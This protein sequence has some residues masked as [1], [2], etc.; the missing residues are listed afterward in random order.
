MSAVIIVD[1]S[2][3]GS[4]TPTS[5]VRNQDYLY[6]RIRECIINILLLVSLH[7]VLNNY[8]SQITPNICIIC[9]AQFSVCI[10]QYVLNRKTLFKRYVPM[11]EIYKVPVL[12]RLANFI[13]KLVA[14]F[15]SAYILASKHS[16]YFE[17]YRVSQVMMY[18]NMIIMFIT[19]FF[20]T[21]FIIFLM[22]YVIRNHR[23]RTREENFLRSFISTHTTEVESIGLITDSVCVVCFEK[24][25][26]TRLQ[27]CGH[28][29]FCKNCISIWAVNCPVCRERITCVEV[30]KQQDDSHNSFGIN[31]PV[32]HDDNR[33]FI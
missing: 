24:T 28:N 23:I 10:Y 17:K 3:N 21:V 7:E 22:A 32:F 25:P 11:T 20:I 31:E 19:Q 30:L 16:S 33:A 26:N 14:A 5:P 2:P 29:S 15:W 1:N 8:N 4:D 18:I 27:P 9:V 12:I 6:I 13:L